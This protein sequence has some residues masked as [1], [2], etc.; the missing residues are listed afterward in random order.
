MQ[1]YY[2][3]EIEPGSDQSHI[4]PSIPINIRIISGEFAFS[5]EAQAKITSLRGSYGVLQFHERLARGDILFAAY[6]ENSLAGFGWLQ[7][8]PAVEAGYRLPENTVYTYD[9]WVFDEFRGN[10]VFPAIKQEYSNYL[11]EHHPEVERVLAH[12]ATWNRSIIR[13]DQAA[14]AY[15]SGVD[16]AI[17]FLGYNRRFKIG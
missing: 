1:L 3:I 14:G 8:A 5:E 12:V 7:F 11:R 13:A 6:H 16:L 2:R 17:I 9:A 15:I 10:R 4:V